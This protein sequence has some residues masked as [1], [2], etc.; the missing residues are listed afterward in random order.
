[1]RRPHIPYAHA[2]ALAF[3]ALCTLFGGMVGAV[4][5]AARGGLR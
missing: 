3:V 5:A 2:Q 4:V 1:M